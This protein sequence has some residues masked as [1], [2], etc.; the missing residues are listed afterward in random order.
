MDFGN[1]AALAVDGSRYC[2]AFLV[3]SLSGKFSSRSCSVMYYISGK[4]VTAL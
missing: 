1:K 3:V 4:Y 2:L